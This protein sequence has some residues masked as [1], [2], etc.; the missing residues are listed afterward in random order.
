MEMVVRSVVFLMLTLVL[1]GQHPAS[2][3]LAQEDAERIKNVLE[4]LRSMAD[5]PTS[6]TPTFEDNKAKVDRSNLGGAKLSEE[7]TE[8][9]QKLLERPS[10]EP[11]FEGKDNSGGTKLTENE[12]IE[13]AL[14]SMF[15]GNVQREVPPSQAPMF[16]GN[17]QREVPPSQPPMFEGNEAEVD[18][19]VHGGGKISEEDAR[20]LDNLLT[21]LRSALVKFN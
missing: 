11:M 8:R 18:K 12:D 20:K 15:E 17:V 14:K 21:R 7:N 2:A 3:K 9:K 10:S 13:S 5:M 19:N 1:I 6:P 16:E 4:R